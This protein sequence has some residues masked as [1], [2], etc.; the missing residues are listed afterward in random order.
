MSSFYTFIMTILLYVSSTTGEKTGKETCEDVDIEMIVTQTSQCMESTL[1]LGPVPVLIKQTCRGSPAFQNAKIPNNIDFEVEDN[2]LDTQQTLASIILWGTE[3][4]PANVSLRYIIN[5]L[6]SRYLFLLYINDTL[7]SLYDGIVIWYCDLDMMS[8]QNLVTGLRDDIKGRG[9]GALKSKEHDLQ[10]K[11]KTICES[12]ATST[13]R[14]VDTNF[15]KCIPSPSTTILTYTNSTDVWTID[16]NVFTDRS[17]TCELVHAVGIFSIAAI[18][19]IAVIIVIAIRKRLG[20][21]EDKYHRLQ[22]QYWL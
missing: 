2:F 7:I 11:W 14:V 5:F 6:N 8:T 15:T 1:R 22:S 9:T 10:N 19:V 12:L 20:G 18:T 4:E 21:I 17:C 3:P 13:T 16:A